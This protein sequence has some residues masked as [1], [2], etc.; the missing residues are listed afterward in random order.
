MLKKMIVLCFALTSCLPLA[1]HPAAAQTAP[2]AQASQTAAANKPAPAPAVS[3]PSLTVDQIIEKNIAAR[4]GLAAWRAIRTMTEAGLVD[5]GSRAKAQLPFK[6]EMMRPR[7]SR[8][9]ILFNG[10]TAVQ[11]YDGT[12]GWTLRPYQGR[13]DPEPFKADEMKKAAEQQDLDGP[14]IDHTAKGIRVELAGVEAVEGRPAYR[15]RFTLKAGPAHNIWIDAQSFLEV[16]MD[17]TPRVLDGRAHAV[18]LY[19]RDYRNVEGLMIPFTLETAVQDVIGTQ[20]LIVEKV[21]L[22]PKLADADFGKP[23]SLPPGALARSKP[24]TLPQTR[25][26]PIP[27]MVPATKR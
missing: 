21:E 3:A 9:E 20:K 23:E 7:K 25:S 26:A 18:T 6:L 17:Q 11:T 19:F 12:N 2:P 16:K 14:L 1:E 4:G 24:V 10:Q 13:L 15:I 5:A 27:N 22:N 8:L